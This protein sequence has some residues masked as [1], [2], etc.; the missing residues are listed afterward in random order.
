MAIIGV[1][2]LMIK[3]ILITSIVS[4]DNYHRWI[5]VTSQRYLC[6]YVHEEAI[7]CVLIMDNFDLMMTIDD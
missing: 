2:D 3:T 1:T 7:L 5:P 4:C 6:V